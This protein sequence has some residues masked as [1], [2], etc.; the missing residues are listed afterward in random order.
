MLQFTSQLVRIV[1]AEIMKVEYPRSIHS[2]GLLFKLN[3]WWHQRYRQSIRFSRQML[4]VDP[5]NKNIEF[6]TWFEEERETVRTTVSRVHVEMG[7]SG[8]RGMIDSVRGNTH[9]VASMAQPKSPVAA[10]VKK[11]SDGDFVRMLLDFFMRP[12]FVSK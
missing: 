10:L 6:W 9:I 7:H 3:F 11:V 5:F 8:H 12:G 4:I 1:V 2:W